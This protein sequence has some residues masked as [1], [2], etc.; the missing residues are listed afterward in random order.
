MNILIVEDEAIIARILQIQLT[1]M[2]HTVIGPVATGEEAITSA[3]K[4]EPDAIL[5]DIRLAGSIDGIEATAAIQKERGQDKD[6]PVIFVTAYDEDSIKERAMKLNPLA[7]LMKP[8][9]PEEIETCLQKI[10]NK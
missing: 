4:H 5:M 3:E 1:K 9:S 10:Q 8:V 6:I 7:Y 2:G